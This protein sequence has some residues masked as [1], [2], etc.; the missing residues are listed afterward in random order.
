M[1]R[2]SDEGKG[3][4]STVLPAPAPAPAPIL[5]NV[6]ASSIR[7]SRLTLLCADAVAVAVAKAKA[8]AKAR[9]PHHLHD[10]VL[11]STNDDRQKQEEEE[12]KEEE[13]EEEE[14]GRVV[15]LRW[16][17]D[18]QVLAL[19][20]TQALVLYEPGPLRRVKRVSFVRGVKDVDLIMSSSSSSSS[21]SSTGRDYWMCVGTSAGAKLMQLRRQKKKKGSCHE[22]NEGKD[23][24]VVASRVLH[25]YWPIACTS[26]SW[27]GKRLALGWYCGIIT[28]WKKKIEGDA[29]STSLDS[30]E[31]EV[32]LRTGNNERVTSLAFSPCMDYL[33]AVDTQAHVCV[34][35][36]ENQEDGW[37]RIARLRVQTWSGCAPEEIVPLLSWAPRGNTFLV[38]GSSVLHSY[39]VEGKWVEEQPSI[40]PHGLVRGFAFFTRG[41][42][43]KLCVSLMNGALRMNE[44]VW[45]SACPIFADEFCE[46]HCVQD[47]EH[48]MHLHSPGQSFHFDFKQ[49][50]GPVLLRWKGLRPSPSPAVP[51]GTNASDSSH[52]FELD[53]LPARWRTHLHTLSSKEPVKSL[54]TDIY[55]GACSSGRI[56]VYCN[57]VLY[58]KRMTESEHRGSWEAQTICPEWVSG[59]ACKL[60]QLIQENMKGN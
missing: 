35:M 5:H 11:D 3:G 34:F 10:V 58:S 25:N 43:T 47:E 13:E 4:S 51:S 18:G 32:V 21:S 57:R 14:E 53:F 29:T 31:E 24:C 17:R 1:V 44:S 23:W 6:L 49:D 27:D 19:A 22:G 16:C 7:S 59:T 36:R 28:V 41:A 50:N 48:A 40:T 9:F 38:S 55:V 30:M 37:S 52:T 46:I 56:V 60:F 45:K 26:F 39:H 54:P 2:G 12:E 42:E 15:S 33:A 8:K 20:T